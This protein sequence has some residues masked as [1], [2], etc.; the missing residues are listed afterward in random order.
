MV[1][2][3]SSCRG[4]GPSTVDTDFDNRLTSGL[5]HL[6]Y[7][8]LLLL[9]SS[10][11]EL[12]NV[13]M[14]F[15]D[16]MYQYKC[17]CLHVYTR[18]YIHVCIWIYTWIYVRTCIYTYIYVYMYTCI[19]LYIIYVYIY[20]YKYIENVYICV[21]IHLYICW[22]TYKY[23]HIYMETYTNSNIPIYKNRCRYMYRHINVHAHT[24]C[25][26]LKKNKKCTR[27]AEQVL[28]L[29]TAGIIAKY[30]CEK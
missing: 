17:V 9:Q 13:Y 29:N 27:K 2:A 8:A 22:F 20:K 19:C 16:I 14:W 10:C 11:T 21:C 25:N 28:V 3:I 12:I 26:I 1:F 5:I 24:H 18:V 30:V 7:S 23:F 4:T 6:P 15:V